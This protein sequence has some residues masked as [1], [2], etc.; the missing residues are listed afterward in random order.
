[1]KKVKEF[2]RKDL[3]TVLRIMNQIIEEIDGRLSIIEGSFTPNYCFYCEKCGKNVNRG[4]SQ[5]CP[6]HKVNKQR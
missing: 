6:E 1:M 3:L 4:R 5:K 2:T